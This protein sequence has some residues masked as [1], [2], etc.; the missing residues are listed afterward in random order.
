MIISICGS[1]KF[2]IKMREIKQSLEEL[3]YEVIIPEKGTE[4]EIPIEA[5]GDITQ[6]EIVAAKIEFDFIREHFRN[7]NQSDAILVLNYHKN[8]IANYIGGNTFLEMGVTYWLQKKIDLLNPIPKINYHAEIHAMQPVVL[9]GSI[10]KIS[11]N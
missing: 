11:N 4:G 2:Y 5:R 9:N 8:G 6:S 3:G 1:M 7:T 10:E